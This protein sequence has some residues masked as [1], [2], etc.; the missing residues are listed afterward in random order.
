MNSNMKTKYQLLVILCIISGMATGQVL[1]SMNPTTNTTPQPGSVLQIYSDNKGLLLPQVNLLNTTDDVTVLTPVPGLMVYNTNPSSKKIN[2]WESGKWN[3]IFNIDDGLAIIKQ[4]DNFSGVSTTG[5]NI[6]TFPATMPLFNLN[7]NTTGWTDLNASKIITITKATN[8]NYIITEGMA[9]INNEVDTNQSFQFAIGVFV[10]GQLK[11]ARKFN[12]VGAQF[13]CDWKKF[14]L[15]GVFE[16][17]SV[18]THTVAVYGRNLP[19]ITSGYTQISYG[20]NAGTCPN[21]NTDMAR[22]FITTQITQ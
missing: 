10:D 11:L 17:L 13:T 12:T 7:D 14:N 6:T 1:I 8:S 3:R 19:K 5:I 15:A 22:V 4:T 21:I 16:N 9:Q 18:G 20:K 2:F